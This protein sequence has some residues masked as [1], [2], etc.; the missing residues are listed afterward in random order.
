LARGV[1]SSGGGH[2]RSR[3][4]RGRLRVVTVARAVRCPTWSGMPA[5]LDNLLAFVRALSRRKR[6]LVPVRAVLGLAMVA[7]LALAL[8]ALGVAWEWRPSTTAALLVLLLGVGGFVAAGAPLMLRWP[9]GDDAL[10]QARRVE[11][12]DPAL[13][14][15]LVTSVAHA[16]GAQGG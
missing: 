8:W 3:P 2:G 15:R 13:R 10:R 7:A 9:R 16:S 14:G 11:S 1:R 4:Q 12:L 5:E 6:G